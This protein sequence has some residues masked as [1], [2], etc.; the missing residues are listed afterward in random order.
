MYRRDQGLRSHRGGYRRHLRNGSI[1]AG[2]A[3]D[4]RH[5]ARHLVR[6]PGDARGQR[7]RGG[8]G[9]G[10]QRPVP[11]RARLPHALSPALEHRVLPAGSVPRHRDAGGLRT[12]PGEH[13]RRSRLHRLG[14]ALH[15]RVQRATRALRAGG[16]Q[17]PQQR[18]PQSGRGEAHAVDD[19]GL[20][21]GAH[22]PLATVHARYGPTGRWRRCI[23][24]H[25]RRACPRPGP[26]AG[27]GQ[28]R[29]PGHGGEEPGRPD[30]ESAQ[31][32]ATGGGRR[33]ACQERFLDRRHR[34]LLPLRR[35][36]ADHPQLVREHRVV[37]S[38]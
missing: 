26:S 5:P 12:R 15:P 38:G 25:H 14:L 6:Q 33:T 18:S 20:P 13:L 30:T 17:R 4:A 34:H 8:H 23:H 27:V 32:R 22:D 35:L 11:D 2:D 1:T 7:R 16:D 28:R 19:G 29:D 21:L 3:D 36:H 9:G 24:H 10:V 37:W 31:P